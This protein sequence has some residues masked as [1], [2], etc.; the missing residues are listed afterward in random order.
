M[1]KCAC[2]VCVHRLITCVLRV[3]DEVVLLH[4]IRGYVEETAMQAPALVLGGGPGLAALARTV[5]AIR[6]TRAD[7][8]PA[9]SVINLVAGVASM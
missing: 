6:L 5:A 3:V 2:P 1:Y 8:A 9:P 7:A 4:D